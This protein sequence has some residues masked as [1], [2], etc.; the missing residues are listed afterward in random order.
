MA[1]MSAAARVKAGRAATAKLLGEELK[2]SLDLVGQ[3]APTRAGVLRSL[4]LLGAIMELPAKEARELR[5]RL[6]EGLVRF[7]QSAM[8]LKPSDL[9]ARTM[10]ELVEVFLRMVERTRYSGYTL[11]ALRAKLHGLRGVFAGELFELLVHNM[12]ELQGDLRRMAQLQLGE[13]NGLARQGSKL[14]VDANGNKVTVAGQFT[15]IRRATEIYIWK[16][17]QKRKFLDLAYVSVLDRD[18]KRTVGMLV[19]TEIKLPGAAKSFGEQIGQA[20][21]RFAGADEIEM[22]VEGFGKPIR[23]TPDRVVFSRRS[24]NRFAVTTTVK[25]TDQLSFSFTEKGGYLESYLKVRVAV[26][27]AELYRM[28]NVLF[29]R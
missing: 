17:G 27:T 15:E 7:F 6:L 9:G 5:A 1:G 24:I 3:P 22:V 12:R 16:D 26:N 2:M 21:T 10:D 4:R 18:G 8:K 14:L 20:Q 19:E 11:R 13:L 28:L 23:V 29:A 25:S